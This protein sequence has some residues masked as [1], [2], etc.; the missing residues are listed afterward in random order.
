MSAGFRIGGWCLL[1]VLLSACDDELPGTPLSIDEL[2]NPEACRDCHPGH[3]A[4]WEGS[5]HAFSGRDPIFLA[6]NRRGQRE[7]NGALGSFCVDCHSPMAVRLGLTEDGLNLDE[8]PQH[9]QSV[10]CSFCHQ[11]TGVDALVNNGLELT[12]DGVMRGGISSPRETAAHRSAYSP[13]HD[14]KNLQS[15]AMCGSCHDVLTPDGFALE[16][17]YVEWAD[18]LFNSDDPLQRNTC[19][20]CHMPGRTGAVA[21]DGPIRRR[22]DHGMPAIDI[23]LDGDPL[24]ESMRVQVQRELDTTLTAELCV[25]PRRGGAEVEVY[26]EN[27][28]A[29]HL[30]PSGASHDRRV[31]IELVAYAGEEQV[32]ESGLVGDGQA[33]E[34]LDPEDVWM[35]HDRAFKADGSPAH[36]FWDVA[37]VESGALPTPNLL[38]PGS[39]GYVDPHVGRRY[40]VV[41]EGIDRFTMKVR[42]R[43]IGF[44]V[45][46]DLISTGDLDPAYRE[47]IPTFDLASTMLTWREDEAVLKVTNLA[48]R[49]A[50]CVP[51][52]P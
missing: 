13:L 6:M 7:T 29:G 3:V 50:L 14:R 31:W 32:F 12:E 35:L 38:F 26:L 21:V 40:V 11:V 22:H 24:T 8:I 4:E 30:F 49:E 36:M 47:T 51:A 23:P 27:L 41:G 42:L 33:V 45:V 18:S 52:S 10:S 20:D 16:R 28:S 9:L 46:D 1:L 5:M 2:R 25:I 15:A 19:N 17:T 44:D 39:P 48:G 37:R 34:E 43:P